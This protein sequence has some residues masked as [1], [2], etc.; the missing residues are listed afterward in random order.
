M[1]LFPSAPSQSLCLIAHQYGMPP[2]PWRPE[3]IDILCLGKVFSRHQA[4]EAAQ[5]GD[6]FAISRT[7]DRSI[8]GKITS[9]EYF[10]DI[11]QCLNV[12]GAYDFLADQRDRGAAVG[13]LLLST[14]LILFETRTLWR[15]ASH[16]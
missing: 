7:F 14:L 5:N 6:L 4:I 16:S 12:P 1:R 8:V 2:A 9:T 13:H 15:S 10:R 3:R 11:R